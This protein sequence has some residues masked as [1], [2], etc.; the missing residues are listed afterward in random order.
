MPATRSTVEDLLKDFYLPGVR[1]QLNSDIF[2]LTQVETGSED[3]EGLETVLSLKVRRNSGVGARAESGTLPTAGNQG[4]VQER[5][6]LKYNYGKIK[7]SGPLMRSG[8]TDA[9]SFTRPLNAEMEGVTT[10]LKKDVNRQLYGTSDGVIAACAISTT[11]T[12]VNM[13]TSFSRVQRDQISEGMRIDI[14]TV[15]NPTLTGS[16]LLVVSVTSTTIVVDTTTVST[17]ATDRIFRAGSG[18]GTTSQKELTGLQSIVSSGDA[19]FGVSGTTYSVWNSYVDSNGGTL[20]PVSEAIF[21]EAQHEVVRRS[22]EPI[23]LWIT[24]DG[25]HRNVAALLTSIK[26][27][28]NTLELKGGYKGLDMSAAGSG[29]SG[30]REV[31]LTWDVD[32]PNNKAFGLNTGKL[33]WHHAGETWDWMDEDGSILQRALDGT[34]AYEATLFNYSEQATDQRNAHCLVSDLTE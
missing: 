34:D 16:N 2:L 32:C 23:D 20:R 5:V 3:V 4:Y 9:G 7:V 18:G 33:K 24:S 27:F 10:D 19:L 12:T 22:G 17:A 14:G 26:R 6:G 29:R 1:N 8:R 25:V 28:P 30:G 11:T 31:A 13:A 15:A 21:E